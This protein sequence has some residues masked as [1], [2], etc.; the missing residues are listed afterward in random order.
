MRKRYY[1][2][3]V[4]GIRFVFAYDSE[5]PELLHIYARHL[6]EPGDA[7]DTFFDGDQAW[8]KEHKRFETSTAELTVFWL[9]LEED[10]A[11]MVISCFSN[12]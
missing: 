7:I 8:N 12:D 4:G 10:V 6:M 3:E 1:H 9:W 11:V 5:A 2:E